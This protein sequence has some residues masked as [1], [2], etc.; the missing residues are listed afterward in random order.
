MCVRANLY[1]RRW[2]MSFPFQNK[3]LQ[4]KKI[5]K[6]NDM[7]APVG[8]SLPSSGRH[9]NRL[10]ILLAKPF[11]ILNLSSFEHFRD[12]RRWRLL[13]GGQRFGQPSGNHPAR[14]DR[15]TPD[16]PSPVRRSDHPTPTDK[17]ACFSSGRTSSSLH[18]VCTSSP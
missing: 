14:S 3:T 9:V 13:Q 16:N 18:P 10:K 7:K 6:E 4:S 12:S 15:A 5:E 8:T 1:V 17:H 11:F 2:L